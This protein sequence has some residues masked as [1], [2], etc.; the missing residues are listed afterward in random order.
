MMQS[1]GYR[2]IDWL[3]IFILFCIRI[4]LDL[5]LFKIYD[6]LS[7]YITWFLCICSYISALS[8]LLHFHY[9]DLCLRLQEMPCTAH[10]QHSLNTHIGIKLKCEPG[11]E[12]KCVSPQDYLSDLQNT[13]IDLL[14]VW[15]RVLWE[16]VSLSVS[17]RSLRR[18][19]CV[20]RD[21]CRS[22]PPEIRAARAQNTLQRDRTETTGWVPA[23]NMPV[24]QHWAKNHSV[25]L[26]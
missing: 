14:R 12:P 8:S 25:I 9:D 22:P 2:L 15:L 23:Q 21:S 5:F 1:H 3:I 4:R 26:I 6:Q 18:R 11:T 7:K 20:S 16:S 17:W 13:M 19:F 10:S 24:S